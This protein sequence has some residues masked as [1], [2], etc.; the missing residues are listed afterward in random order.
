MTNKVFKSQIS[1]LFKALYGGLI[2]LFLVIA[3]FM[4]LSGEEFLLTI[5][6]LV[7]AISITILFYSGYQIRYELVEEELRAKWLFGTKHIEYKKIEDFKSHIIPHTSIRRFGISLLGG[8]YS[9]GKIGKFYAIYTSNEGI[10]IKTDEATI[11]GGQLF[12]SPMN[13]ENFLKRLEKKIIEENKSA[14]EM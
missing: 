9:H 3:I 5:I 10:L 13:P 12:I 14:D 2:T 1:S 11:Y 7:L 4:F 6:F 8:H